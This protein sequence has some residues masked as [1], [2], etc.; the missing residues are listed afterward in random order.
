MKTTGNF[1]LAVRA[2]RSAAAQCVGF[3]GQHFDQPAPN[4]T[5]PALSANGALQVGVD[6]KLVKTSHHTT[7]HTERH[8]QA[9]SAD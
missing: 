6:R 1:R 2:S 7:A 9:L 3:C 5:A 4:S 8:V